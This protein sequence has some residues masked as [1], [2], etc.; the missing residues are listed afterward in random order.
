MPEDL[1]ASL[2]DKQQQVVQA[3][4]GPVL[5]L[6]GAGSGKTRA[7]T[8]RIAY[9]LAQRLAQAEEIMA[10]TFT[11]KAAREMRERV[12]QLVGQPHVPPAIG[13]FHS[14]GARL[15]R[16][17][18]RATNRSASFTICDTNDSEQL[19]KKALHEQGLSSKEWQ[20][21][22]IRQEISRAKN[23]LLTPA[24]MSDKSASPLEEVVAIIYTRYQA[25][26]QRNDA[27]D[28]DD[29]IGEAIRLLA[30][31]DQIRQL[32]RQRWRYLSVDEYQDTNASQEHLLQL[33]TGPEK[34]LCVVGDDYQAIYSWRGAQVDHILR[35]AETWAPCT[36]IYLTQ[37]YR[38]TPSI[39][40]AA[41]H[42]IAENTA[43]KHKKLWTAQRAGPPVVVLALSSDQAE[44]IWVRQQIEQHIAAGKRA[45]EWVIL[46]RTNAQSRLLEEQFIRHRLAYT[47]I[48]GF[49]FY[50]RREVKDAMALLQ[51]WVNPAASLALQRLIRS[52]GPGIGP[53]TLQRLELQAERLRL[54]L[55][56]TVAQPGVA[57]KRQQT[58]LAVLRTAFQRAR[59]QQF[60]TVADLLQYLVQTSGY[61]TW[62]QQ[63]SDGQ[64]RWE[65]I[66]ELFNVA[67]LSTDVRQFVEEIALMSDLDEAATDDRVTCMT[68]HAAK[69]LEFNHV[70]I[71][72]CE[73]GLL[74]HN[75]SF[76]T[77]T[78]L[79]EERR[80][81]YVG[82]TRA[83][84]SLTLT[85]AATRAV[86]GEVLP[87][88]PSRFLQALPAAVQWHDTAD[89]PTQHD[90]FGLQYGGTSEPVS[91]GLD[92]GDFVTHPVFGRGVVIQTAGTLLTCVFQ[93]YGVK[94]ID[95]GIIPLLK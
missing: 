33:L 73:E 27:Y 21:R 68:L 54:P 11:N 76:G 75:N 23:T 67:A 36:T 85:H 26:L 35:F 15:L 38:S 63:Q 69:G 12:A 89:T 72:G 64:E 59:D 56:D 82:M 50:D 22:T 24:E 32:Y 29:L 60:A 93:G 78:A 8:H 25:L 53:K 9:L 10:V 87:Q 16:T 7:L 57:T 70:C 43:Q 52:L 86:R 58:V 55:L 14:L 90:D 5:V 71:V 39:L 80:L 47:I 74:P 4:N 91:I 94:T 66:E 37:N 65:N 28:F 44:A 81:L 17:H 51:L 2:N 92:V 61:R 48:G 30:G 45:A 83:K 34:N 18:Y 13:T 95:S 3:T 79:E 6:A 84:A 62:L 31:H 20:P 46:Y 41:N 77:L 1:L 40:Q 19:I 49:R 88:A 42:I